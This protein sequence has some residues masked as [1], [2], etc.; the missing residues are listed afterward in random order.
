MF[1]LSQLREALVIVFR[2]CANEVDEYVKECDDQSAEVEE[3]LRISSQNV[4]IYNKYPELRH[5]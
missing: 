4:S 1:A 3:T 2:Q 5:M